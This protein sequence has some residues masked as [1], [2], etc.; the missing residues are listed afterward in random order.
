MVRGGQRSVLG[1]E[2]E[3][4][5]QAF[6]GCCGKRRERASPLDQYR[7]EKVH[8][9]VAACTARQRVVRTTPRHACCLK[10]PGGLCQ[11]KPAWP[12]A[13]FKR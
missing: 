1:A 8:G 12:R 10:R 11:S 13:G 7:E 6:G 4:S 2:A 3:R 5:G 9:A